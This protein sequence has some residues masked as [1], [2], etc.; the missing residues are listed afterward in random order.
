MTAVVEF[1]LAVAGVYLASGALFA[2]AFQGFGLRRMDPA[3]AGAGAG[4]RVLITPG[5]I[6]LWP[7]LALR[8]W[9]IGRAETFAGEAEAPVAPQSLRAWHR[10]AWRLLV[11]WVPV[12]LAAAL[13]WR[14]R[15]VPG[16]QIP[17]PEPELQTLR[18][19][20]GLP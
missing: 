2:A 7:L 12:I 19:P 6:A 14:P 9:R 3:A 15:E 1:L 10:L 5:V 8:W 4:F 18:T 11:V 17:G 13:W 20:R 16:S